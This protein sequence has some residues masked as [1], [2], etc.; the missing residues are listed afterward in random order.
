MLGAIVFIVS[1]LSL[2]VIG[3]TMF[4]RAN[5]MKWD[6]C[7]HSHLRRVGLT[8]TGAAA[9]AVILTFYR[10]PP[11]FYQCMLYVGLMCVFITTP[12]QVPWWHFVSK[13]CQPHESH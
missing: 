10:N 9:M 13:G 11:T 1:A 2:I 3:I 12:N 7:W 6:G 4:A 8:L 5:D